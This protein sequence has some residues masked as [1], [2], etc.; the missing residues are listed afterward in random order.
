M[1]GVA[2]AL[3]V[4]YLALLVLIA[5][6]GERL[7]RSPRSALRS[8]L[9]VLALGVY[10]TTWTY[11][12]AVGRAFELGWSYLPIYLGPILVYTLGFPILRRIHHRSKEQASGSIADL[13]ALRYGKRRAVAVLATLIAG[14]ASLPYIGLQ[15]KAVA[16]SLEL[17]GV[18]EI[19]NVDLVLVLALV[20]G[21]FASVF[22]TRTRE[23][24]DQRPGMIAAVAF[25]SVVKLVA[26]AAVAVGVSVILTPKLKTPLNVIDTLSERGGIDEPS[27][28]ILTALAGLAVICLPRQFHLVAVETDQEGGLDRARWLFPAYLA[29][30]SVCVAP[31]AA[32]G[33]HLSTPI[34]P[35]GLVLS[36]P[37]AAEW[38]ALA[39]FAFI[40][41][42]SAA[43]AMI[44]VSAYAVGSMVTNEIAVPL[45]L[46]LRVTWR[47]PQSLGLGESVVFLRRVLIFAVVLV[48]FFYL[49]LQ[50]TGVALASYGLEAFTLIAQLAPPLLLGLYWRRAHARGAV[51]GLAAGGLAWAYCVLAPSVLIAFPWLPRSVHPELL[52]PW[53]GLDPNSRT[54][55]VSLTL[56]VTALVGVSVLTRPRLVDRV[57]AASFVHGEGAERFEVWEKSDG[58]SV[59]DIHRLMKMFLDEDRFTHALSEHR[60][61]ANLPLYDQDDA[62]DWMIADCERALGTVLGVASARNLLLSVSEHRR[63][64]IEEVVQLVGGTAQALRFNRSLLFTSLENLAHGI[65]VVDRDLRLV[66]WNQRYVEFFDYPAGLVSVGC[67]VERLVRFNIERGAAGDGDPE[68]M[69][70]KRIEHLKRGTAY[71][72]RRVLRGRV[73]ELVGQPLPEGG[74][75]TTFSD[76]TEHVSA[77][78]ALLAANENLERIVSER[79]AEI[80]EIN[81][82]LR[83]AKTAAE[84][85]N[86]AKTQFLVTAGHDIL[87]PLSAAKMFLSAVLETKDSQA[88]DG[89]L[90]S[91]GGSLEATEELI[92][93]LYDIA[94][95]D[96]GAIH[97]HFQ[98][99]Q[100]DPLLRQLLA[101][102]EPVAR[103]KGLELRYVATGGIVRG[104]V[105]YLRRI[106]GNFLDNAVKYTETG[107]V[108]IGVR[109]RGDSLAI[110]VWDSG[111]GIPES[112]QENIFN[113]FYRREASRHEVGTGLGL[114]VARRMAQALNA[115]IELSSQV[116]R[117]SR[118]AVLLPAVNGTSKTATAPLPSRSRWSFD[119][120]R[121][122]YVD[123]ERVNLEAFA[124]LVA[125]WGVE[126]V[127]F[128]TVEEAMRYAEGSSKPD[129]L[130]ADYQLQHGQTGIDAAETLRKTWGHPIP[131]VILTALRDP[132]VQTEAQNRGFFFLHK[133]L[134]PA[135]LRTTLRHL[136]DRQPTRAKPANQGSRN[137]LDASTTA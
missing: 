19:P 46:N 42:F 71:T 109:R 92:T 10:C 40:G 31:I 130:L 75:V 96:H 23:T 86:A 51:A 93:D 97:P 78:D 117:G 88:I 123:D 76:I 91:L 101:E 65:S 106:V 32:Y 81:R 45:L 35:D 64:E 89:L 84:S 26:L 79:T 95:L 108:L 62:P 58:A 112:E 104:D 122:V 5:R 128:T 63:L 110:E 115:K 113:D 16:T 54:A 114:S 3:A 12:G 59:G 98:T 73:L 25:E 103:S 44:I 15:L 68:M 61:R 118:F 72:T 11:Y 74:F 80:V 50:P 6:L 119:G 55:L 66:A 129:I 18:A 38:N 133:P 17:L 53:G 20:L 22:G 134:K 14:A 2:V 67:P 83:D 48:A 21:A 4:A 132:T 131:T 37:L 47:H 99:L 57:Q 28:W 27:F 87:Q 127:C 69:I 52:L 43:T 7:L 111:P 13:L 126:L 36:L 100:L 30:M 121:L 77:K 70:R 107:R 116:N 8:W 60:R 85:A 41:G 105:S 102:S 135:S 82:Q 137:T 56:N 94:K 24:T 1:S 90:G 49:R 125:T 136:L 9:P 39:L 124:A 29:I 120:A 34:Q 33:A